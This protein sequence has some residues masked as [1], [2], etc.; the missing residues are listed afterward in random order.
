M[1]LTDIVKFNARKYP[2]RPAVVFQGRT[3]SYANLAERLNRLSNAL[4]GIAAVGD[5]VAILSENCLE[6]VECLYAT[7]NS[8]MSLI[9]LNYRLTTNNIAKIIENAQPRVLITEAKYLDAVVGIRDQIPSVK[10]IISIGSGANVADYESFLH[11]GSSSPPNVKVR[12]NDPAW[13]IYTSG[14]TGM[15][16]GTMLSHR[17]L[18]SSTLSSVIEWAP[19]P[20]D[21]TLFPLPLCHVTAQINLVHH[22][23]G[24]PVVIMRRFD[25]E[26]L[27]THIEKYRVTRV[28]LAPTMINI[29]LDYPHIDHFDVSSLRRIGY[30]TSPIPEE[31]IKKA[32][33]RF[34]VIFMQSYGMTELAN[35]VCF[36]SCDAHQRGIKAKPE[37]LVSAG[38][39]MILAEVRIVDENMNDAAI[40]EV[41]EIVVRGNQV[42]TGYWE[43]PEAT[44]EAFTGDWFHTGDLAKVDDEGYVYIV[45]RKKDMIITGGENVYPREIEEI[46][47]RHPA[48]SEVAVIGVPDHKWGESI[49]AVASLKTGMRTT[50]EQIMMLCSKH[51]ASYKKPKKVVFVHEFPKNAAG[52]IL[53]RELRAMYKHS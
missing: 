33:D 11:Q 41:G 13:L 7:P 21:V 23:R 25:P 4:L 20:D 43:M 39:P 42:M 28:S 29:L 6:Y 37:L 44:K 52:K 27:L 40:G 9:L 14:T 8:G 2:D 3:I 35:S 17:N 36:L 15:P 12:E 50:E 30:G 46:I 19:A 1:L 34:G 32:I 47:Y 10:H 18:I 16:K 48:V 45:D 51:L 22:L 53:K 24:L 31:V 26:D 5:R 49:C 38:K